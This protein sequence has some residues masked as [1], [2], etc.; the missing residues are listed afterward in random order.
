MGGVGKQQFWPERPKADPAA[1]G[2]SGVKASTVLT[3]LQRGNIPTMQ[4][5]VIEHVRS[6]PHQRAGQGELTAAD[7]HPAVVSE[8]DARGRTPLLWAAAYGQTPTVNKLIQHGA[9][10]HAAADENET[11][12]HLAAA[13]GHHDVVRIL[14]NQ[15]AHLL[16]A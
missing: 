9:D 10:V 8:R 11:A 5:T 16:S 7:L 12:L 4:T 15:V 3:N 1:A 14:L 13:S 2:Q 6:S